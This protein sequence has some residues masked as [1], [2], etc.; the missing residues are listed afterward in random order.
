MKA[1]DNLTG[2]DQLATSIPFFKPVKEHQD[3]TKELI[4]DYSDEQIDEINGLVQ[5]IAT[6]TLVRFMNF[7]FKADT[8]KRLIARII[9]LGKLFNNKHRQLV[10]IGQRT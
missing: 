10:S 9:C 8:D 1:L 3:F 7:L 6:Q 2:K 5:D 4:G